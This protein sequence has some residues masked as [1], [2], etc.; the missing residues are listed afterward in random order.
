MLERMTNCEN[1]VQES[2][3]L[4]I[5]KL[6]KMTKSDIE[7]LVE[8]KMA[9]AVEK[10][11]AI[12][13]NYGKI[14]DD[15]EGKLKNLSQKIKFIIDEKKNET[16]NS[17][18]DAKI[19]PK[20]TVRK[21]KSVSPSRAT[22]ESR[23][24][25]TSRTEKVLKSSTPKRERPSVSPPKSPKLSKPTISPPKSP[26]ISRKRSPTPPKS[27]KEESKIEDFKKLTTKNPENKSKRRKHAEKRN[28]LEQLYQQLS[29]KNS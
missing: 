7:S 14:Q 15:F 25:P 22:S 19:V 12:I 27:P 9:Q 6:T 10:V 28:K 11:L 13:K 23:R 4:N 16:V 21:A 2:R 1:K 5:E 17:S 24:P 8:N 18:L 29:A 26:K 3:S 20:L